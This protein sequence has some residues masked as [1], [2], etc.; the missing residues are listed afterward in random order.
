MPKVLVQGCIKE[1]LVGRKEE[2]I[3]SL[4][5]VCVTLDVVDIKRN[6]EKGR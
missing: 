6:S 1:I 2:G 4:F 5:G 3:A